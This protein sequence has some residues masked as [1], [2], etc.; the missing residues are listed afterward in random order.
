MADFTKSRLKAPIE[1]GKTY[2][3][4]IQDQGK[5]GD[6]IAKVDGFVIFVPGAEKGE[7]CNVKVTRVLRN[8]GFAEK[9]E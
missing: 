7:K 3:V 6:G 1:E 2:D 9:V 5:Q 8:C 4:E